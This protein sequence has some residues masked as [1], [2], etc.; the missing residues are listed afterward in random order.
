MNEEAAK[1][2]RERAAREKAEKAKNRKSRDRD[3]GGCGS[4]DQM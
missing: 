1:E 4:V 2:K 3:E